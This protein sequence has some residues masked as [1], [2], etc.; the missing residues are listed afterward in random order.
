MI[1]TVPPNRCSEQ[2][3]RMLIWFSFGAGWRKIS[4]LLD[5]YD[6]LTYSSWEEQPPHGGGY[7]FFEFA[8]V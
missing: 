1:V 4:N 6:L 8:F 3:H 2:R 5:C 7:D